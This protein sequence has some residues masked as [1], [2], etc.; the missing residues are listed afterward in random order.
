MR[1]D[2]VL[3]VTQQNN[4]LMVGPSG[5]YVI[6]LFGPESG[7]T[8]SPYTQLSGVTFDTYG[9]MYVSDS[10]LGTITMIPRADQ[11]GPSGL[12]G[13]SPIDLKKLTV[14]RGSRRPSDIKLTA[15][16]DGL[17]FYDGERAFLSLRF[18]MAGQVVD[19]SGAP[20]GG[21]Q[22]YVPDRKRLAVTD[23]DGVFVMPDL[24][25][26]GKSPVI[27]FIVKRD[28]KTVSY[29]TVLDVYKHNIVDVVYN[30]TPPPPPHDDDVV[31]HPPQPKPPKKTENP[32]T[33]SVVFDLELTPQSAPESCPRGVFL[34]PAFGAG[35]LTAST[36]ASGLL[37]TSRF[38]SALLIVNGAVTPIT[39]TDREFSTT[40]PLLV[41]ENVMNIALPASALKP[42]GCADP[43]L[44][45]ATPISI[46]T[47]H[48]VFHDPRPDEL[49]RY[50]TTVG[51]D[52][53][54][55]GIVREGG[56]AIAGLGF[57][58]PG[59]DYAAISD[60][61][62]VF[63]VNL[64][65]GTLGGATSATDALST[66]MFAKVGQIVALLRQD[67]RAE[68]LTQLEALLVQAIAIGE[69]PPQ[70]AV[71]VDAL[72]AQ[73]LAVEGTARRLIQALESPDGIPD[74]ADVDA[75]EAIATQ[76]AA[77]TSNGEIVVRGREYPE[78][79]ITVRVQ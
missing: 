8:T 44:D 20:V 36:V 7:G 16:R 30:P 21:A 11:K 69:T 34:S 53:S 59:T 22:V 64:P 48:K 40:V 18:G 2:L 67:R 43:T 33:V 27:D 61:D 9:N 51:F 62:G 42:L 78:L 65:K 49:Q 52:L 1:P 31:I 70:A 75:L 72:L 41:G 54:V 14:L 45:D 3:A 79:S 60:A 50:R 28:G 17:A 23:T 10:V 37:T 57:L 32:E 39:L 25:Q 4:V 46:S 71:S 6:P 55:R 58:V 26:E 66:Q 24:V 76:L 35:S 15:N 63:Q 13:L 47:T 19:G 38:S 12:L 56:R 77:A 73:V 74:P 29:S 68:A 5:S